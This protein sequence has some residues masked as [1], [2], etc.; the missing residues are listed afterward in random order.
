MLWP[1]F[2]QFG[3]VTSDI[4]TASQRNAKVL[5]VGHIATEGG[6][7][8]EGEREGKGAANSNPL[9]SACATIN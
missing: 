4:I 1:D 5:G 6:R 3:R 9:P 2:S 7:E 8:G